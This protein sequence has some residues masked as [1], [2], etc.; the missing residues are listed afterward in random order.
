MPLQDPL[1]ARIDALESLGRR[2]REEVRRHTHLT[3]GIRIAPTKTLANYTAKTS[4]KTGG[5]V[6]ARQ[7]RLIEHVPVEEVWGVGRR[8]ARRLR[9]E[10]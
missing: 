3:V 8:I 2:L 6:D 4:H 7:R 10:K 1:R 9:S 5:V